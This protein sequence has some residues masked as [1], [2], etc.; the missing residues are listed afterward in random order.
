MALNGPEW[1]RL[2]RE[3]E[4]YNVGKNLFLS[5]FCLETGNVSSLETFFKE[6]SRSLANLGIDIESAALA[7]ADNIDEFLFDKLSEREIALLT[8][9]VAVGMIQSVLLSVGSEDCSISPSIQGKMMGTIELALQ[10]IH[11]VLDE[12]GIVHVE[13]E[14]VSNLQP[15]LSDFDK[16]RESRSLIQSEIQNFERRIELQFENEPGDEN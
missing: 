5:K 7:D 3:F 10:R 11:I 14:L 4:S 9:G 13:K 1:V 15:L 8:L 16:L 2:S 12:L 6:I